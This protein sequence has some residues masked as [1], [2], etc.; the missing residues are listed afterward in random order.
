MTK[1]E[2]LLHLIGLLRNRGPLSIAELSDQCGISRRT[3]YRDINSLLKMNIPVVYDDGYQIAGDTSLPVIEL[4]AEELDLLRYACCHNPASWCRYFRRRFQL[5]EEKLTGRVRVTTLT[6]SGMLQVDLPSS[7]RQPAG[8][9]AKDHLEAFCNAI[10]RHRKVLIELNGAR[11][12]RR[13]CIP[14]R[15]RLTGDGVLLVVQGEQPQEDLELDFAD[16]H[17]VHVTSEVFYVPHRPR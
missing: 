5:I 6:Q 11:A 1:S 13:Y 8:D 14:R 16:V 15:I 10:R 9:A 2:R 12:D 17:A 3:V 7:D 4:S